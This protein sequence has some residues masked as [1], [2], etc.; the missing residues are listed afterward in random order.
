M[1]PSSEMHTNDGKHQLQMKSSINNT[2]MA[3]LCHT[4]ELIDINM[5]LCPNLVR[6]LAYGWVEMSV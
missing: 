3:Q 1:K 6:K 5:T 2:V 4:F